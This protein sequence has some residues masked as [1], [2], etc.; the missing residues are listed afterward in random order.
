MIADK[1]YDSDK[2][3]E[4][5]EKTMQARAVIPPSSNLKQQRDYDKM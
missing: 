5:V 1:C 2:I 3:V 4:Q